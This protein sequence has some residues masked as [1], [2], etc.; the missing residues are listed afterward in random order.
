MCCFMFAFSVSFA[1]SLFLFLRKD[2]FAAT[3]DDERK[4][5]LMQGLN[6]EE[7]K[8][9]WSKAHAVV[10]LAPLPTC[11]ASSYHCRAAPR[12]ITGAEERTVFWSI[13]GRFLLVVSH[14]H[15][16]IF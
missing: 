7:N 14:L 15:E 8:I 16:G 13:S 3:S 5:P 4:Q 11:C 9:S 12:S 10:R 2:I 1:L 6:F